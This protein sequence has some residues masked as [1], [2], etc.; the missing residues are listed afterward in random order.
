MVYQYIVIKKKPET[1]CEKIEDKLGLVRVENKN[2][3]IQ[4]IK[5]PKK[6]KEWIKKQI[7]KQVKKQNMIVLEKG[8]QEFQN[9]IPV[10][11]RRKMAIKI[12][13]LEEMIQYIMKKQG[14]V[15]KLETQ[16]LYFLCKNYQEKTSQILDYFFNKV[17]TM[18]IVTKDLQNFQKY[19]QKHKEEEVMHVTIANNYRKSLK[20]AKWIINIDVPIEEVKQYVLNRTGIFIQ[21]PDEKVIGFVGFEGII[22]ENVEVDV[23]E[24]IKNKYQSWGIGEEFSMRDLYESEYEVEKTYIENKEKMKQEG[25]KVVKLIGINGNIT[26]KEIENSK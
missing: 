17:R 20:R 15:E 23:S 18:N 19:I 1:T 12:F 2:M 26:E 6:K 5:I 13:L 7:K 21:I 11:N 4:I 3:Q 24:E 10:N 8:L 14:K 9:I 25:I 16:D 22:V